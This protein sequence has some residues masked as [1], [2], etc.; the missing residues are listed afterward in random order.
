MVVVSLSASHC[1][2]RS[3]TR[4]CRGSTAFSTP[5]STT[6]YIYLTLRLAPC[7]ALQLYSPLQPSSLYSSIQLYILYTQ[8]TLQPSPRSRTLYST[9]LV[10][11]QNRESY[12]VTE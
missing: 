1:G 6:L 11:V 10:V 2:R 5:L 8:Y 4:S 9:P 3:Y 7:R 12:V